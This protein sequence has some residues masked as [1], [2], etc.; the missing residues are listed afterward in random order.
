[1][2]FKADIDDIKTL[3]L[4]SSA[5]YLDFMGLRFTILMNS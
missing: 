4:T 5:R 1:M 2:A 3:C